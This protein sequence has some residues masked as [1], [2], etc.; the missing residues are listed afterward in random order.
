MKFQ[1]VLNGEL[2]NGTELINR[3]KKLSSNCGASLSAVIKNGEQ[4]VDRFHNT[5]LQF[6]RLNYEAIDCV[7]QCLKLGHISESYVLLRW[8]LE[9]GHLLFFLW[10]NEA[11]YQEWVN[12][13]QIKPSEI[14][15]FLEAEG[16]ASWRDS[17]LDWSN[18]THSNS[19]YIEN[20]AT[21]SRM[22]P[23]NEGQILVLSQALR[24]LMFTGHKINHISGQLLKDV[25]DV[26]KY[27]PIAMEYNKLEEDIISFSDKHNESENEFLKK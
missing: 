8:H 27:N 22:N 2:I 7:F 12:G 6:T 21:V 26:K 3:I 24:N 25:L 13:E 18:V 5:A 23:I 10:K 1:K 16:Y 14:G 11:K 17:Y 15:N 19:I 4:Q 9:M 20:C